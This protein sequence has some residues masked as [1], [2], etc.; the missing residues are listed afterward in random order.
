MN[1][2]FH[3]RNDRKLID[4]SKCGNTSYLYAS[5]CYFGGAADSNIISVGWDGICERWIFA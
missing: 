3:I 1:M 4:Y 2:G 5:I